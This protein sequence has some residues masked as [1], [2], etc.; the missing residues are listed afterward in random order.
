VGPATLTLL[1]DPRVCL[2]PGS[3][4]W[5]SQGWHPFHEGRDAIERQLAR[6]P[7]GISDRFRRLPAKTPADV[8]T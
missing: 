4:V 8:S 5:R 1:A 2:S 3:S 6:A 7:A